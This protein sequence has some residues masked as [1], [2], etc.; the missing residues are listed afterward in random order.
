MMD[1]VARAEMVEKELGTFIDH[2]SRRDP[3]PDELEASYIESVRRHHERERRRIRAAWYA[4]FRRMAV[5]LRA[6][7]EEYENRA[8][9][10]CEDP[11]EGGG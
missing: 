10:L 2:R 9:A 7:A 8:E 4:F 1:I 5:A 6:R 3:D 11:A